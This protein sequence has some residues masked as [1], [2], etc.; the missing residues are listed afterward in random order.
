MESS[1]IAVHVMHD[2]PSIIIP[3]FIL[4]YIMLFLAEYILR[5]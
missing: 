5:A 2:L 1:S 3:P 4:Q